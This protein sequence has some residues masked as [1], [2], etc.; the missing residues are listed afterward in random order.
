[1]P[2]P[3][4]RPMLATRAAAVPAGGD[5]T[6]E[7]KWDGYRTLAYKEGARVRLLS[8]NLSDATA[9][10]PAIAKAIAAVARRS[11]VIDGEIV[12]VD[13]W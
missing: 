4:V 7:V 9:Q 13:L 6:Y 1:M 10:Y 8:R 5:W 12:A 11:V 3:V 2:L